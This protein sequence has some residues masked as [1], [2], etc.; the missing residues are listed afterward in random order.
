[1]S[2][3]IGDTLH[4]WV[5]A[6]L[7]EVTQERYIQDK[8]SQ[9]GIKRRRGLVAL[10]PVVGG[11]GAVHNSRSATLIAGSGAIAA[12]IAAAAI[13][14][15]VLNDTHGS[16][17]RRP[18]AAAP[19]PTRPDPPTSARPPATPPSKPP[20]RP[21]TPGSTAPPNPLIR[22]RLDLPVRAA[23]VSV[24]LPPGAPAGVALSP[25]K[26][27]VPSPPQL[28]PPVTNRPPPLLAVSLRPVGLS[29]WL[30]PQPRV[31]VR[32]GSKPP[33]PDIG[34]RR[35]GSNRRG[36]DATYGSTR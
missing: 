33:W 4:I 20:G 35:S 23:S 22:P 27:P 29:V 17:T 2:L 31:H 10:L 16:T 25:P 24:A 30:N 1:M 36:P 5:G 6:N 3:V 26:I 18:H 7:D 14:P 9:Y 11:Q 34:S 19:A 8:L 12:G 21:Q 13:L 28:P 15:G 32:I